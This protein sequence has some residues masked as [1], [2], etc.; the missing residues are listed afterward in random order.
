[1]SNP[2]TPIA[3]TKSETGVARPDFAAKAAATTPRQQS[4]P[5]RAPTK[6]P[7][8]ADTVNISTAA[9]NALQESAETSTQTAKEASRGDHQAQRLLAKETAKKNA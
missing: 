7:A 1:M 8:I 2:I 9:Q 3:A 6:A 4:T 5:A